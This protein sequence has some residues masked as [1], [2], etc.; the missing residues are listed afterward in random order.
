MSRELVLYCDESDISGRHFSNFYG[1]ALVE[2]CHLEEV[3]ST[4]N[5]RKAE[6]NLGAEVKWQKI[7][8][9]YADKYMA[10]LETVFQLVREQKLKLRVMFTQNYFGAKNLTRE[11]RERS[12]FVLYYQFVKHA[13]GLQHSANGAGATHLRIYFDKLPDKAEKCE[14]FKDFVVRLNR[15]DAFK[16][17]GISI[18]RDQLAEID[19]KDHVVLQALD[20]VM[21]A[22][23]FRLNDK[24][25]EKPAGARVR[26]KRT[27]AKEAVYKFANAQIRDIYPGFN[28]GVSTGV[29]GDAAN[30]WRHGYRH[31]LFMPAE[32]EIRPEFA[33]GK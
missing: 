27:R 25:L 24:H 16:D 32:V 2:S 31:W 30:R 15:G 21:G 11:Q 22:M 10:L 13:F 20:I 7:S 8:E 29:Q 4:L 23:Q 28:I 18:R 9:A 5:S 14:E 6:L 17:A 12:F 33:K 19:S 1:G 3:I 26:G